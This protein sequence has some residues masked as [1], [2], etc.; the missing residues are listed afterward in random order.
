MLPHSLLPLD[1]ALPPAG[2]TAR[3]ARALR[4]WVACARRAQSPRPLLS[5]L[6]GP[7]ERAFAR[8][9]EQAVTAW[10]DPLAVMPPCACRLTHDEALLVALVADAR[11]DDPAAADR[12]LEEMFA[13]DERGRLWRA[14]RDLAQALDVA[15]P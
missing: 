13:R 1:V 10:P 11:G 2:E 7:A 15:F 8:F 6:L 5:P 3:L 9:M 14:A 4:L 12:R